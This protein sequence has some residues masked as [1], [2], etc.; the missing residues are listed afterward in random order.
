M[1]ELELVAA[2]VDDVA[3]ETHEPADLL[4]GALPVLG[5]KCIDAQIGN[6]HFDG[7][8]D[9]IEEGI[10]ATCVTVSTLKTSLLGPTSIAVHD[11]GDVLGDKF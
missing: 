5:G 2:A 7:S 4:G 8:L 6:T 3:I 11:D 10:L 9:D 1:A